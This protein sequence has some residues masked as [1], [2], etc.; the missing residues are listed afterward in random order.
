M[1]DGG[2]MLSIG[3][4]GDKNMTPLPSPTNLFYP[5]IWDTAAGDKADSVWDEGG[6][7]HHRRRRGGSG[8][9]DSS[10]Q[11]HHH[12][13]SRSKTTSFFSSP[14][15]DAFAASYG[16]LSPPPN[17]PSR[18][19]SLRSNATTSPRKSWLD[20]DDGNSSQSDHSATPGHHRRTSDSPEH[21]PTLS[22]SPSR[23]RHVPSFDLNQLP[24]PP[25]LP[26]TLPILPHLPSTKPALPAIQ[27]TLRESRP[28]GSPSPF[29]PH[30]SSSS[31]S[32]LPTAVEAPIRSGPRFPHFGPPSRLGTMDASPSS[33]ASSSTLIPN[34]GPRTATP[35]TPSGMSASGTPGNLTPVSPT[36]L[37][38]H[39]KPVSADD[40]PPVVPGEWIGEFEVV[41][42]LGMGS[43]SRVALAKWKGKGRAEEPRRA[44]S[45]EGEVGV[46]ALKLITRKSYQGNERMRIS[47]VREV[48]V[49]KVRFPLFL[50]VSPRLLSR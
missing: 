29:S 48:E 7:D 32:S 14:D 33:A 4:F 38:W 8:E 36:T 2:S 19:N 35:T 21:S 16:A 1:S 37:D 40:C 20:S 11:D 50:L 39:G 18:N 45:G 41:K 10:S 49:L 13:Q 9:S 15:G 24:P 17:P 23:L 27:T 34:V 28:A 22:P 3:G 12:H 6:G 26:V 43:F 42:V 31:M 30:P 44:P 47:V 25:P 46:F 5:R